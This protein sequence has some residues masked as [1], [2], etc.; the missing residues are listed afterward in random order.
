MKSFGEFDI[1]KTL[2]NF[3]NKF[4]LLFESVVVSISRDSGS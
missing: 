1:L 4:L 2:V 3:E